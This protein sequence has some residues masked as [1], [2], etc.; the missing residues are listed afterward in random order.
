[1]HCMLLRSSEVLVFKEK[2]KINEL[3]KLDYWKNFYGDFKIS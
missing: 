1:M 3:L 2:W